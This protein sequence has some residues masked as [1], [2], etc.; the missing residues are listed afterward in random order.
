M[1]AGPTRPWPH[2][3]AVLCRTGQAEPGAAAE[4]PVLPQDPSGSGRVG[5]TCQVISELT[6]LAHQ[7]RRLVWDPSRQTHSP[8][9]RGG[10]HTQNEDTICRSWG[11]RS[12]HAYWAAAW[13]RPRK[14][15]GAGVDP[16]WAPSCEAHP[17]GLAERSWAVVPERGLRATPGYPALA[18]GR[19]GGTLP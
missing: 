5:A 13:A 6:A 8:G 4:P 18:A 7:G 19:G 1:G 16:T 10:F 9:L 17:L 14:T 3:A 2:K 15:A 12:T 11:F